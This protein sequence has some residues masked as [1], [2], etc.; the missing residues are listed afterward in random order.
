VKQLIVSAI[1]VGLA[2]TACGGKSNADRTKTAAAGEPTTATAAPT[3]ARTSTIAATAA[4]TAQ[5]PNISIDVPAANANVRVPI[6]VRGTATVFEGVLFVQLQQND[7]TLLCERRVQSTSGTGTPWQTTIAVPPPVSATGATIRAFSRSA[8]DGSEEND[9][10]RQITAAPDAP[11]IVILT[12]AC[13]ADIAAG[14]GLRVTG[15]A[16]VFEA[17]LSLELRNADGVVVASQPV[18]A[19]AGAP[20]RGNW[21]ATVSISSLPAGLY[22][23]SAFDLSA[24]DGSRENEFSIPLRITV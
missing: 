2:A 24:R 23:L 5:P 13:N 16:S 1:I 3:A 9:V 8:R 17:A 14:T 11:A 12:P 18:M 7:G 4:S 10:T 21:N 20:A 6:D 19:D 22:E 15:N